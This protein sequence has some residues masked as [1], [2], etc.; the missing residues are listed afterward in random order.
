[1]LKERIISVRTPC[2]EAVFKVGMGRYEKYVHREDANAKPEFRVLV[3]PKQ[4]WTFPLHDITIKSDQMRE[5]RDKSLY[6][7]QIS[8]LFPIF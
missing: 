2:P 6:F 1:M 8:C 5:T 3:H 7:L 4:T